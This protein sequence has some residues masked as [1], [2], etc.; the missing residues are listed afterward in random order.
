MA[1][2]LLATVALVV[3]GAVMGAGYMSIT[4]PVCPVCSCQQEAPRA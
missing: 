4:A 3:L 2:Q 1:R